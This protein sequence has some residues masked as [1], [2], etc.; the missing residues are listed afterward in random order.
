MA[1]HA[2]RNIEE[3]ETGG[4]DP[5][6]FHVAIIMDG[7]GRWAR[8]RGLPHLS[9]HKQGAEALRSVLEAAHAIGIGYLT[10]YGFSNEN[11]GRPAHEV[12]GLMQLLRVYL[13]QEAHEL[14]KAG[15]RFRVIGDRSRLD[16]NIAAMITAIEERTANNTKLN[17]TVAISYGGRSDILQ[18]AR[19]VAAEAVAGRLDPDM[20]DEDVFSSHLATFDL[21]DP[22]LLIR[23][24]GELRISNF[25][26]WQSAYTELAFSDKLWPDFGGDDLRALVA[27]FRERDRRFGR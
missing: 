23:T 1:L 25:L 20:I 5:S 18:A 8:Q 4:H 19:S 16:Q 21:P 10:V 12:A 7:N 6:P 9:G 13:E 26:L 3:K 15:L 22:D 11:W 17:F 24:S 27:E 14:D 2:L